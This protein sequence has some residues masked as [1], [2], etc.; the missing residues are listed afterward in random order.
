MDIMSDD[1]TIERTDYL[2]GVPCLIDTEQPDPEAAAAFYGE[3]FDWTFEEKLPPGAGAHYLVASVRGLDV[4][5][6]ASPTPGI[7]GPATWN[8]YVSVADA[9]ATVARAVELGA[10]VL[11]APVDVGPPGSIAGRWAAFV[12]PEGAAIRVWQPGY[13]QGAQLVN[14]PGSWSS[15]DLETADAAAAG[16]FYDGVFGWQADDLGDG[17]G[18]MWRLPGYGDFL[19]IRDP[20]IRE[21]HDQPWVPPG[22]SDAI[23][24]MT[25]S[26]AASP[27]WRVN[28]S[29]DDTDAVVERAARLG[30]TVLSPPTDIF[31]GIVRTAT[32]EDPAGRRAE[33]RVLRPRRPPPDLLGRDRPRWQP[34]ALGPGRSERHGPCRSGRV[35]SRPGRVPSSRQSAMTLKNATEPAP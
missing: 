27:T 14:A 12:D 13:R 26:S 11:V 6:V 16:A 35:S 2:P 4:A 21:R 29:V 8:T 20:G 1:P 17:N 3:L 15:S 24:W 25:E 32:I 18:F 31:G 7:D 9:D 22:F 34:T 19:A 30:A 23:G 33:R 28:I 10:E 5:A